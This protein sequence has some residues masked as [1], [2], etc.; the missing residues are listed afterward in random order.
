MNTN[1]EHTSTAETETDLADAPQPFTVNTD[2]PGSLFKVAST[3]PKFQTE[4][5]QDTAA[6]ILRFFILFPDFLSEG[7][8]EYRGPLTKVA[9][10]L[11]AL[12]GVAVADGVLQRLNTIP[13][14]APTF[15]LIGLGA[16]GWFIVRYLLYA[17]TRQELVT[18]Y[19]QLKSKVMG[20]S[21]QP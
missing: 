18:L 19:D 17:D 14:F 12:L 2:T 20:G 16:T 7:F 13:L 11:S 1:R 8:G 3:S 15:E 10:V 4:Q 6:K 21:E 9:L 5:W